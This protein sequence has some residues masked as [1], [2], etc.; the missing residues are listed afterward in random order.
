MKKKERKVAVKECNYR[1]D[2]ECR[3]QYREYR[4]EYEKTLETRYK[5]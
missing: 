4:K 1:D 3:G 2:N 5:R